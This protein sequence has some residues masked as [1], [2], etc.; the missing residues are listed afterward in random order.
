MREL[1]N[2][3]VA[4][5][6]KRFRNFIVNSDMEDSKEQVRLLAYFAHR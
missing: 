4:E 6:K 2:Q 3:R 1:D 5:A